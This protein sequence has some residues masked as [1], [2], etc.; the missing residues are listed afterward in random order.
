MSNNARK[1]AA[2][3]RAAVAN[4][5]PGGD[6]LA[7]AQGATPKPLSLALG[8]AGLLLVLTTAMPRTR[9]AIALA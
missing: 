8:F 1:T 2:L 5:T 3:A 9:R 7:F 6:E 4:G